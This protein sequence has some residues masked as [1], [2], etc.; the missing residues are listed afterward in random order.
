MKRLPPFT[1]YFLYFAATASLMPYFVRYYQQ[2]GF[3]GVEIGLLAGISPLV[4]LVGAP[5]WTGLADATRRH[6]LVMTLTMLVTVGAALLFPT[7]SAFLP[8]VALTV[9]NAFFAAPVGSLADSATLAVLADEKSAYG[10][11]RLGGTLGWAVAAPIAGALIEAYG[12]KMAFWS[13]A[14]MMALG[15]VVARFFVAGGVSERTSLRLGARVLFANRRWVLFLAM[16]FI[17]GIG[18]ASMNNYLFSYMAEL[19]A[20]ASL[21]GLALTIPIAV[22]IPVM[23]FAGR[24]L[25]RFSAHDMMVTATIITGIRLLLYAATNFPEGVLFFQF[26]N[27]LTF[28]LLWVAGVSYAAQISPPGMGATAQ[29]IFGAAVFG[30]GFATAGFVGGPLLENLGG[31]GLYF[32]F[33]LVILLGAAII[34]LIEKRLPAEQPA[35]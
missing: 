27:G 6:R 3:G 2:L 1:F 34:T 35:G 13:Y 28:P 8:V 30:F 14:L 11:V 12:L 9:L 16:A 32:V 18:I 10:R 23:F 22:E 21:M 15:L 33:G 19:N 5:L 4:N 26:L 31:R 17:A 25:R 20:G 29:G 24:L 7:L